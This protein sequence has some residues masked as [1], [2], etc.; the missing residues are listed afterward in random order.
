MTDIKDN[1]KYTKTHEWVKREGNVVS[2]GVTS[3]ATKK[4]GKDL[5][6]VEV[7]R[8]EGDI[9]KRGEEIAIMDIV[10]STEDVLSPVSGKIL[11]VNSSLED[12]LE[13]ISEDPYGEGWIAKIEIDSE[14]DIDSL[15][16]PSEYEEEI[17]RSENKD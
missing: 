13:K 16:S 12:E 17:K 2:I 1:L 6:Y 4:M 8:K 11:S 3:Y 14:E 15:L 9:I 7:I 10:K 5:A